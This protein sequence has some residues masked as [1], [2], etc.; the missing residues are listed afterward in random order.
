MRYEYAKIYN[1][2]AISENEEMSEWQRMLCGPTSTRAR[3]KPTLEKSGREEEKLEN[4]R[5]REGLE[6]ASE[7][8]NMYECNGWTS[9][10]KH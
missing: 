5:G 10:C 8:D 3:G 9:Q 1:T 2:P 4:E 7:R 6:K